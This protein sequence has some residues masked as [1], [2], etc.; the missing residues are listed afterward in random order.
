MAQLDP[1]RYKRLTGRVT[2]GRDDGLFIDTTNGRLVVAYND[3]VY[4]APLQAASQADGDILR[5]DASTW[6]SVGFGGDALLDSAGILTLEPPQRVLS[7][8]TALAAAT[9]VGSTAGTLGHADGVTL[10]AGVA[11]R[12]IEPVAVVIDYTHVVA[13][14]TAGGNTTA[15]YAG[16]AAATGLVAAASSFGAAANS[17]TV[18]R[19]LTGAAIKGAN[20]VLRSSAAFTQPGTAAGTAVVKTYYRVL[21]LDE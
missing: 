4:E 17:L 3:V 11:D 1:D 19:Q 6:D 9:I 8:V 21:P 7:A 10:V 12:V 18:L 2:Y 15:G 16:G 14:Y 5:R 13:A 20:L